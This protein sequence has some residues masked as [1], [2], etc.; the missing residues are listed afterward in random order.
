MKS[1]SQFNIRPIRHEDLN[2][3]VILANNRKIAR[4]MTNRFPSPYTEEAGKMFIDFCLADNNALIQAI[5]I[6]DHLIGA[7]GLHLQDDIMKNNAELA[8]WVGEPY[9]NRGIVTEA[10]Q[11]YVKWGFDNLTVNRIYARPFGSNAASQRVLEK[12]G[13]KLE[14]RIAKNIEK[15]GEIEDELIY[16]IRKSI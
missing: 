8:Y 12:A 4:F 3:L 9:W 15:W 16:A 7:I 11:R 2:D 6:D 14:A 1:R 5:T 10:I 13:F